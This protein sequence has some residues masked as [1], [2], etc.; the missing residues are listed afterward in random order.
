MR[1]ILAD[2]GVISRY[3]MQIPPFI[4]AIDYIGIDRIAIS[5]ITKIELTHWVN[6]YKKTLGAK[7]YKD[8]F[9]LINSFPTV[10][11]DR[12]ISAIAIDLSNHYLTKVPDLLIASTAI[13][14][15]IELFT[16]NGKDFKT[17]KGF[18]LYVPPNDSDVKKVL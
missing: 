11:I 1:L 17:I 13:H 2:T 14:H 7:K 3:V 12:K 8:A 18:N 10:H 6:G 5:A 16:V 9:I 15:G 4:E